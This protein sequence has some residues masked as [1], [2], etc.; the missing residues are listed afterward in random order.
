MVRG[1]RL[2]R[3]TGLATDWSPLRLAG[4]P[5]THPPIWG[6][7]TPPLRHRGRPL[8]CNAAAPQPPLGGGLFGPG[9]RSGVVHLHTEPSELSSVNSPLPSVSSPLPSVSS[10]LPSVSSPLPSVSS[11]LPLV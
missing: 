1:H 6:A 3:V 5:L 11:P 7:P 2:G 9:G 10:P 4:A 8:R